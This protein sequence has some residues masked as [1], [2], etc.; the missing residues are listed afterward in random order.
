[1]KR[2]FKIL[3]FL[4]ILLILIFIISTLSIFYLNKKVSYLSSEKDVSKNNISNNSNTEFSENTINSDSQTVI[5]PV[6]KDTSISMSVIGDIMCHNTQFKDAYL[7]YL[8]ST[9]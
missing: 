1:M 2:F 9:R 8:E 7:L 6:V 5:L 4:F 3:I